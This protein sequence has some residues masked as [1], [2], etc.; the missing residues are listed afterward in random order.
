MQ[1]ALRSALVERLKSESFDDGRVAAVR[2]VMAMG[3]WAPISCADGAAILE[4]RPST[5]RGTIRARYRTR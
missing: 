1:Q 3:P 4:V 5:W 2:S